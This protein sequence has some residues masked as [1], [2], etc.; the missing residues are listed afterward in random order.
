MTPSPTSINTS[1]TSN[2]NAKP[3][4]PTNTKPKV[5][6]PNTNNNPTEKKLTNPNN[7]KANVKKQGTGNN[8]G[9]GNNNNNNQGNGNNQGTNNQSKGNNKGTNNKGN[10]NNKGNSS[11]NGKG[12]NKVSRSTA[13]KVIL[14]LLLFIIILNIL[15]L[16]YI[17]VVHRRNYISA[18]AV[19]ISGNCEDKENTL[20]MRKS[21]CKFKIKYT[22]SDT[23]NK[24]ISF[25][26]EIIIKDKNNIRE[27]NGNKIIKIDIHSDN[28]QKV[29]IQRDLARDNFNLALSLIILIALSFLTYKL[30]LK[31]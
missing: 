20:G 4:P 13:A 18:D 16:V 15:L 25:E 9:K 3:T 23:N 28:Y 14:Y 29:K 31:K 22:I 11:N 27:I 5:T 21:K 6:K 24:N 30:S 1:S 19:V 8:E 17:N 10:G 26:N 2:K 7:N 12:S